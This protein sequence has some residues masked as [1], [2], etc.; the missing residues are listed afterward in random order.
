VQADSS[1]GLSSMLDMNARL[2]RMS[3]APKSTIQAENNSLESSQV[4]QGF[5]VLLNRSSQQVDQDQA[6]P[7]NFKP[8]VW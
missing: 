5:T 1:V 2:H 6:S 8:I 7:Q 3:A 4:L